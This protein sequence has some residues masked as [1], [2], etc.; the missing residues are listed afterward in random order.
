MPLT[1]REQA[2]TRGTP[3]TQWR[4][5]FSAAS[6]DPLPDRDVKQ[7]YFFPSWGRPAP[8]HLKISAHIPGT[9]GK[10]GKADWVLFSSPGNDRRAI[11]ACGESRPPWSYPT[12]KILKTFRGSSLCISKVPPYAFQVS[13]PRRNCMAELFKMVRCECRWQ[14]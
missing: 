2:V 9:T 7:H 5:H 3:A 1:T 13:T 12:S 10:A 14:L 8:G 6:G 4:D 11:V